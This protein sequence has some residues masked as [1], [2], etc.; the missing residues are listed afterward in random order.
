MLAGS[1]TWPN[2]SAEKVPHTFSP[3]PSS[4]SWSDAALFTAGDEE[5]TVTGGHFVFVPARTAHRY[6]GASDEPVRVR[7]SSK[8]EQTNLARRGFVR[9]AMGGARLERATSCL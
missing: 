7:V 1:S 9:V 2:S 6:V 5:L 8:V 3:I 4:S